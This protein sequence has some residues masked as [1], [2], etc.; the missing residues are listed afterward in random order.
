MHSFVSVPWH[1][2]AL[3]EVRTHCKRREGHGNSQ[4]SLKSRGIFNFVTSL[5]MFL[6]ALD[7]AFAFA[8]IEGYAT[9]FKTYKSQTNRLLGG[10]PKPS[11]RFI[12]Q[13]LPGKRR[14]EKSIE[15]S[16]FPA[17][18]DNTSRPGSKLSRKRWLEKRFELL[19]FPGGLYSRG[20]QQSLV[21]KRASPSLSGMVHLARQ[22]A[23]FRSGLSIDKFQHLLD[24]VEE[25]FSF[26]PLT[27]EARIRLTAELAEV[28]ATLDQGLAIRNVLYRKKQVAARERLREGTLPASWNQ[29]PRFAR[30]QGI[31]PLD[32]LRHMLASR[33]H[34]KPKINPKLA[35]QCVEAIVA[36]YSTN[37][38]S[39]CVGSVART[40]RFR[41]ISAAPQISL[42][43]ALSRLGEAFWSAAA[44]ACANDMQGELPA[45]Q[46][47]QS[48]TIEQT[49]LRRL[50]SA[51]VQG[52]TEKELRGY[53]PESRTTTPDFIIDAGMLHGIRWVDLKNSFGDISDA[54]RHARQIAKYTEDWGPGLIVFW[55]GYTEEL[56]D[57]LRAMGPVWVV[58]AAAFDEMIADLA[59]FRSRS[60]TGAKQ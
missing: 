35:N 29:L 40:R 46:L 18:V 51:G 17:S 38:D 39:L 34:T 12:L 14:V 27:E 57:E 54:N 56:A 11:D 58:D 41:R 43:I 47:K 60:K 45:R 9:R 2:T 24:I 25:R 13:T 1:A 23:K 15:I 28:G 32:V 8:P 10:W 6:L 31:P 48:R 53:S 33:K 4:Y 7:P 22:P 16:S 26:A 37:R 36:A 21:G 19:R 5:A 20:Q 3:L 52:R 49:A 44:W 50:R 30:M 55:Q 42:R 59:P